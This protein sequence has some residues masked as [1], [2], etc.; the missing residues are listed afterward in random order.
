[1]PMRLDRITARALVDGGYM[2]LSE[3]IAMFADATVA[4]SKLTTVVEPGRQQTHRWA[5]PAHFANPIAR[6]KYRV[7]YK[8]GQSAA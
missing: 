2:P 3:Y 8:S 1:M 6:S 5:V 7:S 4:E